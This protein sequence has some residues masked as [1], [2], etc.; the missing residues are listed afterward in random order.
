MSVNDGATAFTGSHV[1]YVDYDRTMM[2][3]FMSNTESAE[4][5]VKGAGELIETAYNLAGKKVGAR[6]AADKTTVHYSDTKAAG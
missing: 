6:D 2:S 4:G 3:T 5:M 1:A